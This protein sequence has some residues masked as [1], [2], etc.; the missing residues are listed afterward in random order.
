MGECHSEG[1]GQSQNKFAKAKS[2]FD[3]N[4][5]DVGFLRQVHCMPPG[6]CQPLDLH[7]RTS[8]ALVLLGTWAI[9]RLEEAECDRSGWDSET[10]RQRDVNTCHMVSLSDIRTQ[11]AV[12]AVGHL[13]VGCLLGSE[14]P[15]MATWLVSNALCSSRCPFTCPSADPIQGRWRLK[16]Y[17]KV[18][19]IQ[20]LD[21]LA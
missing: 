7:R 18:T 8:G 19:P 5:C 11:P 4:L 9:L 1:E 13:P 10:G 3:M 6:R 15:L 14:P 21:A 2:Y 17:P 16:N 12:G 20:K